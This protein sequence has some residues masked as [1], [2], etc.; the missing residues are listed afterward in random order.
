MSKDFISPSSTSRRQSVDVMRTDTFASASSSSTIKNNNGDSISSEYDDDNYH[1]A[2]KSLHDDSDLS[3]DTHGEVGK[4]LQRN[5]Q[6]RHLTMISLGGT[7]GTGLFLASGSSIATAGPGYSQ[8]A[9]S[10]IGTM[11][12][13]FM[14]SLGEMATYLPITGSINAYGTRF[15][16]PALGFMLGWVY[17]FSWSVTLATELVASSVIISYWIPLDQCPGWVWAL[18]FIIV[19]TTLNMTSVRAYGETEYWLSLI[20]VLAVIVFV[21]VGFLYIGG[22][23]GTPIPGAPKPGP[24]VFDI[25][26][27]H[28]GFVALFS[29]FLNAGF[30]FQGAELVG[31]A[32]GETKNPRK[33]VPRAIKQVFWRILMFY[34]LTI[35]IIGMTIPYDDP[36]L[37]NADGDIRAS[38]FTRVFVQAGIAIGGD[39]MNAVILI[40]VL[41]AGNSGLYASSRALHTLSQEGNAPKFFGYVNR[42]G[43]PV[44]CV[45]AT[46]LIGCLAFIVSLPQIGQGQAYIW[47][48]SLASTTGFIA[49]LGI[50]FC[51]LR[52]RMAYRAQGRSL[53]DLPFV[54]QLYPF[55]PIY[56]IVVCLIILL[57]QGYTAFSPFSIKMFLSAYVTLPFI[58]IL[59]FGKKWWSKT[60]ILR[61]IDVDL[62]TGRSYMDTS[63]PVKGAVGE[64]DEDERQ[65]WIRRFSINRMMDLNEETVTGS[66]R[67]DAADQGGIFIPFGSSWETP[68]STSLASPHIQTRSAFIGLSPASVIAHS[69]V[70]MSAV[71]GVEENDT[72]H[73]EKSRILEQLQLITKDVDR[74]EGRLQAIIRRRARAVISALEKHQKAQES[75]AHEMSNIHQMSI[76]E[77]GGATEAGTAEQSQKAS[78]RTLLSSLGASTTNGLNIDMIRKQQNFTNI[79]FASIQNHILSTSETGLKARRY[80]ITGSCFQLEFGIQFTVYEPTLDLSDVQVHVPRSVQPELGHFI[81]SVQRDSLLLPFFQTLSQYAQMDYD[82]RSLMDTLAGRFPQ[83]IKS[84]HSTRK[85]LEGKTVLPGGPGVQ[86]LTFSSI[87]RPSPELVLHWTIDVAD[88]GQIV[89]KVSLVPRMPR[90]WRQSDEKATLDAIPTQFVRLAQLKGTEA[91]VASLLQCVFGQ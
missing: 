37:A 59:Y 57:G 50:A 10:I 9:Y 55:G 1:R 67:H 29:I 91:A 83:L 39:I 53:R 24:Q 77:S 46:T 20:K 21:I 75:E 84:G 63:V 56:T 38:P 69:D 15:F 30:S 68:L 17:W 32:A 48:L 54:S 40:A 78:S 71:S 33:N 42:H 31:I 73:V 58:A 4:G 86:S 61:L 44:Y 82:R 51:H 41:S 52:F 85:F 6:A 70:P 11:V 19:L 5:L 87:R 72:L 88:Q 23:I 3:N 47:L 62:D 90:K 14:S 34:V 16:D 36:Q 18:V 74:L 26:P 8:I 64:E 25:D 81:S 28:G 13:C 65:S 12:F 60:K 7:I 45:L 27:F 43:V 79:T 89:P 80:H 22:A 76:S 49:W 35:L 66:G 2:G